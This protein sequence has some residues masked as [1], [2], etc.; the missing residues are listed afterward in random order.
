MPV[1][2]IRYTDTVAKTVALGTMDNGHKA[3]C[4]KNGSNPYPSGQSDQS[5]DPV[6]MWRGRP[7]QRWLARPTTFQAISAVN[8]VISDRRIA[9]NAGEGACA[10]FKWNPPPRV[11]RHGAGSFPLNMVLR[12]PYFSRTN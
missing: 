9:T 12:K 10:T 1:L 3:L 2:G 5:A 6:R 11:L 8:V 7:R 4:Y